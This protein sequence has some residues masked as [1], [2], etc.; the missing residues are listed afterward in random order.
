M[1]IAIVNVFLLNCL[2][3]IV[4]T[5]FAVYLSTRRTVAYYIIQKEDFQ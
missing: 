2:K 1:Q 4:F 5:I 3:G